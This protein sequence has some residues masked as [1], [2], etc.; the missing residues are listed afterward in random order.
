MPAIVNLVAET[1]RQLQDSGS[2]SPAPS[3]P[4]PSPSPPFTDSANWILFWVAGGGL[5]GLMLLPVCYV[6]CNCDFVRQ[7]FGD[8]MATDARTAKREEAMHNRIHNAK[9]KPPL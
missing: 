7:W 9:G 6:F 2:G 1:A 4:M 5:L 8:K 3:P